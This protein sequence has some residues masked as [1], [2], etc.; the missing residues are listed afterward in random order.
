[1]VGWRADRQHAAASP[2]LDEG[3]S[4]LP[5]IETI[6]ES[7]KSFPVR[8]SEPAFLAAGFK[9]TNSFRFVGK[10]TIVLGA[11]TLSFEGKRHRMF[12]F[13]VYQDLTFKDS[14]IVAVYR[15]GKMLRVDL[16]IEAKQQLAATAVP[17]N[18]ANAPFI[19]FWAA[20]DA[21]AAEIE[22]LLPRRQASQ[23]TP[24]LVDEAVFQAQLRLAT[25]KAY[26]TP[27]LVAVNILVFLAML[28]LGAGFL[29]PKA[30]VLVLYGS[31]FGPLTTDGQWW[32]LFTSMF[33]HFG[34]I[35]L[36]LNM[37]ALYETGRLVERLYGNL[38]FLVLYL[39]AGLAGSLASLLWNPMVNSVGASGAIFGVFGALLAFMVN[40]GN[41]VPLAAMKK[42][43][44]ST[45]LFIAN[46]LVYGFSHAGI[47][48]AAHL[49]GL[50]SGFLLGLLIARPLDP[51]LRSQEGAKRLVASSAAGALTLVLLSFAVRVNPS[52][53]DVYTIRGTYQ[54]MRGDLNRG[55]AD[56]DEA[57]K[58]NP[59]DSKSYNARGV[60]RRGKH[61]QDQAIADFT[62]ALRLEPKFALAYTNRGKAWYSKYDFERAIADFDQAI[63]FNSMDAGTYRFRGTTLFFVGRYD[64][65]A[66]DLLQSVQLEPSQPYVLIW[67]YLAQ[68]RGGK[69]DSARQELSVYAAS[70]GKDK[71]PA[72]VIDFLTGRIDSSALLQAAEGSRG[73]TRR[74]QI[75]EAEFYIGE[76]HLLGNRTREARAA[77]KEAE[78]N[79]PADFFEAR[80]ATVE[81]KGILE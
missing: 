60:A 23:G 72:P 15:S 40:K 43:R 20:D 24:D 56:F 8:F 17:P 33:L 78:Q 68:A 18:R 22:S 59:K 58:L 16:A 74:A 73:E 47:D 80:G 49:G 64:A 46:S 3:R 10:G 66:A 53:A 14:S 4:P 42:Q 2:Q 71:W 41:R 76:W 5:A 28:A 75:C 31:N 39:L 54:L 32:R 61:D 44:A 13:G 34:V 48:N 38:H 63:G 67:R 81:L 65:A 37:W 1:M 79:C 11:G 77:L 27:A 29:Q 9:P 62:E 70:V 21:T 6:G 25:P 52:N 35:H 50:A 69:V 19:T 45:L 26:V 30:D 12:W 36:A 7:A 55:I 51:A 57:I